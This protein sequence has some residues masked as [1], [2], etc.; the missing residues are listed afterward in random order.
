MKPLPC[1]CIA[2]LLFAAAAW[3][4]DAADERKLLQ[5]TW[6]PTAAELSENPFPEATLQAMK[7]VIDGDKYTV[8][9]GKSIDKGTA[10]ID[11]AAKPKTM[12]IIGTE[13]PNKGKTF[14]AIYELNGDTLRICYDLGGKVRPT[15]FKTKKGELLFLATY[16]RAKS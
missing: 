6:L 14:L 10:K 9:V 3:S 4:Q 5:G 11:P 1:L 8:T 16:K 2:T 13:G 15:E 12:D 7:L